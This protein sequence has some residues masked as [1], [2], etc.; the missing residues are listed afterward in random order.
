MKKFGLLFASLFILAI[1]LCVIAKAQDVG[2]MPGSGSSPNVSNATGTLPIANGGTACTTPNCYY[3]YPHLQNKIAQV[4]TATQGTVSALMCLAGDSTLFGSWATIAGTGNLVA[5]SWPTAMA[6]FANTAFGIR[7]N[8]NGFMGDGGASETFGAND[9]RIVIGGWAQDTAIKSLGGA[10]FKT[11]AVAGSAMT[12]TPTNQVDTFLIDYI[13]TPSGGTLQVQIDSETAQTFNTAGTAGSATASIVSTVGLGTHTIKFTMSA[14]SQVNL[15]GVVKSYDSSVNSVNVLNMGDPGAKASDWSLNGTAYNPGNPAAWAAIPCDYSGLADSINDWVAGVTVPTYTTQMQ[16]AITAMKGNANSDVG[17]ITE[18]PSSIGTSAAIQ[19]SFIQAEYGLTATN[20]LVP[21]IDIFN[22]WGTYIAQN[23]I[24][25]YNP[26][27][28]GLHPNANGY[29][30][31]GLAIA[32]SFFAIPG[33]LNTQVG[34]QGSPNIFYPVSDSQPGGSIA[35]GANAL[36][37]QVTTAQYGNTAIGWGTLTGAMSTAALYN[38][39]IG[40]QA[41]HKVTTGH[42]NVAIGGGQNSNAPL[43]NDT[44]GNSNTALGIASLYT[45]ISGSDNVAIGRGT[46]FFTTG[47]QNSSFGSQSLTT[48]SSGGNNTAGGFSA[49]S[50]L[51]TGSN[52]VIL[53][54]SV[55]STTLTTGSNNI[56]IGTNAGVDAPSSSSSTT[57][58]IGN[59]IYGVGLG[60]SGTTPIGSVGIGTSPPTGTQFAIG[61]AAA[62]AGQAMCV[63]TGGATGYCTSVVGAG[64]GCTC[65]AF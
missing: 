57:M 45:N 7:T 54:F 3:S 47:S 19:K 51:T 61:N 48:T 55:A 53:G 52:N 29:A 18:V 59:L 2:P 36:Q 65:T 9:S 38:T 23:A 30:T 14:G 27:G 32:N 10:T 22:Q 34:N 35:I 6:G 24:G 20:S 26:N 31:E 42:Q 56:I 37:G 25:M 12:F 17:L 64:G 11:T 4:K 46:Q 63:T 49:G 8:W 44:T 58:N 40:Y 62:H 13:V 41:L 60:T 43:F 16:T 28:G 5:G 33:Q 1:D 15:I 39:V 21:I 50:A